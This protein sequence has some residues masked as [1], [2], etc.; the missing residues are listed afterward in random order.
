MLNKK[1]NISYFTIIILV[2]FAGI[3]IGS[4]LENFDIP[5]NWNSEFKAG[6]VLTALVAVITFTFAYKGLQ[7]NRK[8]L[9]LNNRPLLDSGY[10]RLIDEDTY[11]I[12]CE[13]VGNGSAININ[14]EFKI[15]ND[16]FGH[17]ELV[18]HI[19]SYFKWSTTDSL[20]EDGKIISLRPGSRECIL[21][22]KIGKNDKAS[23]IIEKI[24]KEVF[25]NL[26]ITAKYGD[27]CNNIFEDTL[28]TP[29]EAT[30]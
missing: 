7:E 15:S 23:A 11:R 10:E 20:I 17:H 5:L 30:I 3:I 19:H 6:D 16:K 12:Y 21:G 18:K 26:T 24:E 22:I 1:S 28:R 25:D 9:L 8:H 13:N 4:S 14:L 2:L 27:I 29:I